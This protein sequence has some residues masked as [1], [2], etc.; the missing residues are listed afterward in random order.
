MTEFKYQGNELD[1]FQEAVVWKNYWSTTLSKHIRGNVLEVGAGNGSNIQ[2][3]QTHNFETWDCL[4]PDPNLS[5]KIKD[6]IT[7]DRKISVI[8]GT[9]DAI[10]T[11]K[12]Y[13][14]IIYIDVLEHI[15]SDEEELK[16]AEQLLTSNGKIVIL[17]PAHEYLFSEFDQSIGHFRRYNKKTLLKIKPS[18]MI[19]DELFYIDSIGFFASLANKIFLKSSSPNLKQIKF[20]DSVLVRLSITVDKL[21]H[22]TAGKTI[23]AILRK[24]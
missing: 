16:K 17:S 7:I 23:I 3:F 5:A 21:I 18:T 10:N 20:W 6:K 22:H 15:K 13:D 14:T 4:E 19:C 8:T 12:K 9:L 24:K 1:L 11:N 2:I